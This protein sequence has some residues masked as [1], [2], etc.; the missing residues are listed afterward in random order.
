MRI[1]LIQV[2]QETCSFNPTPTTLADFESFGIFEGA[3]MLERSDSV[4]PI[5]GYLEAVARSGKAVETVPVV[6]GTAQSGGRL[7]REAFEFFDSKVRAGL[8]GVGALDGVVMLLHG[9]ASAAELDDVEGAL[10]DSVRE[11]VG[12]TLPVA[13]M[14][15]HHANV[16]RRMIERSHILMGFRTQPHDQFETSRDLSALAVRLFAGQIAPA[17]AW[18]KL[19][20]MTHQEQY[21]TARGPMKVLFDRA[22][23]ME[24]DPRVLTV[25]PFPMQ[26]WLDADEAG[27][28][29][30]A[31]TDGEP[32]LAEVLADE[33]ADLAWSMRSEFQRTESVPVD[34]AV[35]RAADAASGTVLL[36]DTGDSVLGGSGGDSTVL[37]DAI[38]RA[39][40]RGRAVVPMI[41][42]RAAAH[43]AD[44]GPGATVSLSIGGRS[45]P[46]F[47]PL[48]V[49]G[50]VRAVGDGVV[51]APDLPQGRIN[52]GR[53]VAFEV[54]PVT[55][56]VSEH[57]GAGGIH[58]AAY[59]HVGVEPG[60]HQMV[61]M[62]TASNFQ[63]MA[64][65][66]SAVVRVA[67]PGPTQ[68]DLTTLP[69]QRA[70]RPIFPLDEPATWRD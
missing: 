55:M 61:V 58:P 48:P 44:A 22:R 1:A 46:L 19:R 18:R 37:L 10:L 15:D 38:L 50:V 49:T 12:P 7:T 59:R 27:W 60:D 28:S 40:V 41:D 13:V 65:L 9:A 66:S 62:K 8:A 4:G 24:H 35:R 26:C 17:T 11:V 64:P 42:A 63:Y 51:D 31:V 2:M 70:P 54:G 23:E 39:D 32:E 53:C 45:T 29:I 69:W 6:R 34:E 3:E 68:S 33:L 16:T 36:S 56:L 5:G 14:L 20:M 57:P 67:T 30:V 52:M 43:L 21:L 25:S 47:T